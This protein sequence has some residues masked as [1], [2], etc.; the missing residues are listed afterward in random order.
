MQSLPSFTEL[1]WSL[2]SLHDSKCFRVFPSCTQESFEFASAVPIRLFL[3]FWLREFFCS[4]SSIRF[5]FIVLL[6]FFLIQ[7]KK[8]SLSEVRNIRRSSIL[9]WENG[10]ISANLEETNWS[11]IYYYSKSNLRVV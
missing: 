8:P 2:V 7:E 5:I 1:A 6:L 3:T 11:R 10:F 9:R 4:A